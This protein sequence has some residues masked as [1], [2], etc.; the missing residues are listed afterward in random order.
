MKK[1]VVLG[2]GSAGAMFSNRMRK[3]FSEI[4]LEITV[5]ERRDIHIYQPALTLVTFGYEEIENIIRPIN[6]V[7]FEG[8]NLVT[9]EVTK[10]HPK[11]NKVST[12][13]SGDFNYDYLVIATGAKLNFEPDSIEGFKEAL[14]KEDKVHTFYEINRMPKLKEAL[15][16]FEG[17]TIACSVSEMPI[18]CPAAPMK[19]IMLAEDMMRHRGIRDKCKF[20]FTT[21]MPDVFARQ[22][23]AAKLNS[24]FKSRGIESTPN[25]AP[26]EIDHDKGIVKE[27]GGK[28]YNFDLLCIIP[29]HEGETAIE[30]SEGVSDPAGWVTCDKNQM[31]HREF[32][33]IYGIGDAT[34]FPTSKTASGARIQAKVL[35]ERLKDHLKG[36]EPTSTYDGEII[37]PMPTRY[38]R[39][40]FAQFNYEE[41][42]S[43]AIES[44]ANWV[45]KVHMLRPMY[46]NL[47]L[48]ALM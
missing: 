36:K 19:F 40:L 9:D 39:A 29:P 34:D 46:W 44:Y 17:G 24:I 16:N 27:Y 1:I 41:S 15:K 43:P 5:I 35:T 48:N 21:T 3:E 4:E 8:I 25:F 20:I 13:K 33:N 30:E 45:I 18:K 2:G 31:I 23:Y 22:P 11:D 47:M 14:D 10:V 38:K 12:A 42:I 6:E 7:F 28:Q 32:N 26:S 37:C